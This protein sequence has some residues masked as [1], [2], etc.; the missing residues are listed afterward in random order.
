MNHHEEK[1]KSPALKVLL[2]G[3]GVIG[4]VYGCHLALA[5]HR[6][7]ILAHGER[8]K[9]IN[10]NG[11]RLYNVDSNKNE[12]AKVAIAKNTVEQQYDLVIVAVKANQLSS[13]FTTIRTLKGNPYIVILGNNPEGHA[14]FPHDIPGTITLAFPGVAGSIK[15]GIVHYV[16]I[17]QQPTIVEITKNPVEEVFEKALIKQHFPVYK[18]SNIEGWLAYHAVFISCISIAILYANTD[19]IQLGNDKKLLSNMCE[20]IEEG[21]ALLK[22][23]HIKGLPRN[24][25]LLHYPLLRLFAV[26]YWG[27]F[28]RLP[29]GELYFAAHVRHAPDEIMMLKNWVIKQCSKNTSNTRHL[30]DLLIFEKK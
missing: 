3:S 21:F 10:Q 8:E 30:I 29:K 15:E 28:M 2:I 17:P 11:I 9:E 24:L 25:G 1:D 26:N 7:W 6:V 27:N 4:S 14:I 18:T 20:A 23:Q 16:R 22:T 13:I 12:T 19:S 5:G